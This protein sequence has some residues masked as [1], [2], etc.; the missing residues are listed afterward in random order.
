VRS[1]SWSLRNVPKDDETFRLVITDENN[2]SVF[3]GDSLLK[4]PIAAL[5]ERLSVHWRSLKART[6]R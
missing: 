5:L 1:V 4:I 3:L 2:G 6:R